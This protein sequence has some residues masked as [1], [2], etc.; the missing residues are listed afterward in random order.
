MM[1]H[2][3]NPGVR[4][5]RRKSAASFISCRDLFIGHRGKA[6]FFSLSPWED[7]LFLNRSNNVV[8]KSD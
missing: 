1:Q 5:E 2:A 4:R 7:L 8:S 6:L 3:Q